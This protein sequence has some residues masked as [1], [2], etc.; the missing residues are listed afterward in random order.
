MTSNAAF[1]GASP[2]KGLQQSKS[3]SVRELLRSADSF[4]TWNGGDASS[5]GGNKVHPEDGPQQ[6][7]S[8][9]RS[10]LAGQPSPGDQETGMG[11]SGRSLRRMHSTNSLTGRSVPASTCEPLVSE[12]L[13]FLMN[14]VICR[15]EAFTGARH[16]FGFHLTRWVTVAAA[17]GED[18]ILPFCICLN[19]CWLCS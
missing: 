3:M 19:K 8:V 1:D 10:P 16:L 15:N 17:G 9:G 14:K 5:P 18:K 4:K 12:D 13:A 6:S 11:G 7:F 2:A